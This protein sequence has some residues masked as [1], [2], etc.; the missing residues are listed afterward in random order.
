MTNTVQDNA[1]TITHLHTASVK[2]R[3]AWSES[4]QRALDAIEAARQAAVSYLMAEAKLRWATEGEE[5]VIESLF[6][7]A[8]TNRAE[9]SGGPLGN[10]NLREHLMREAACFLG[11]SHRRSL[12]KPR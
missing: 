9:W 10:N 11:A 4:L 3:E 7:V 2:T 8:A 6:G 5:A 12:I 1:A